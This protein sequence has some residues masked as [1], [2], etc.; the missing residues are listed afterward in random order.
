MSEKVSSK[1]TKKNTAKIL[2]V[3][4]DIFAENGYKG[5]SIKQI[6]DQAGLPKTNVLYYFKSKKDLYRAVLS[7]TLAM[8]NSYF[9]KATPNDDPT[10][11]LANYIKEKMQN[12]RDNP[13]GSKLFAMEILNNGSNLGKEFYD[14]HRERMETRKSVINAWI[15]AG[16][17]DK[18]D[19]EY[20]IYHIWACTQHYADFSAQIR[21]LK[22]RKMS[23]K[24]FDTATQELTQLSLKGC[25]LKLHTK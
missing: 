25:G 14:E 7:Q 4:V 16:K 17:M 24:D 2:S 12:S 22:G 13:A 18:V 1:I 3:A 5:A 6:A 8:W 20:L 19:P 15:K 9:D 21:L 11:T 23:K 10:T